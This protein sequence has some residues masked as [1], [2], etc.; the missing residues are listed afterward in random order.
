M[1][2]TTPAVTIKPKSRAADPDA[3]AADLRQ[4]AD[5]VQEDPYLATVVAQIFTSPT[6]PAHAADLEIRE[7]PR[8][9]MAETIRQFMTI[10][11]GS[12]DKRYLGEFF[13][14]HI[15]L[16]AVEIVLADERKQVCT[17][18]VT[19]TETVT[20]EV[21]DPAYIAD[22]PMVTVTHEVETIEWR[23]EPLMGAASTK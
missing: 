3:V 16:Q 12:V 14:A 7:H 2:L 18:V 8:E 9:L 11:S 10:A 5:L 1:N 23:C 17:R 20:E 13:Y 21:P 4:I 19:G 15:P 6:I 22:A